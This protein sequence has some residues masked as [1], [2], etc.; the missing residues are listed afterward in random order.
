[1]MINRQQHRNSCGPTAL[2]NTI[3]WLGVYKHV[4]YKD[5]MYVCHNSDRYNSKT[6]MVRS[7]LRSMLKDI[8]IKH[9]VI[10]RVTFKD[11]DYELDRGN[12]V[13]LQYHHDTGGHYIFID[14]YTDKFYRA[15]ND[16]KFNKGPYR[17]RKSLAKW[18]RHSHRVFNN[19]PNAIV[20]RGDQ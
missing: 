20:I 9:H 19:Y 2:L 4:T 15:W 3:K 14:K 10:R 18:I 8:R 5:V 12:A 11:I 16:T 1:M 7:N 17:A 6:G 13:I